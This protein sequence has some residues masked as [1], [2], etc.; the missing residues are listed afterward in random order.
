MQI[1]ADCY[2]NNQH[3]GLAVSANWPSSLFR[4]EIIH[5]FHDFHD[6]SCR[7]SHSSLFTMLASGEIDQ[8]SSDENRQSCQSRN[9]SE[10]QAPKLDARP[11]LVVFSLVVAILQR[12]LVN[13]HQRVIIHHTRK[14][15]CW[16][17][18]FNQNDIMLIDCQMRCPVLI[19][20]VDFERLL[21]KS[22]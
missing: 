16:M 17:P 15:V 2:E 9:R 8:S 21:K 22:L 5:W 13:G 11:L 10:G 1:P 6:V 7:L 20:P 14:V 12:M 4:L 18:I 19:I 3:F